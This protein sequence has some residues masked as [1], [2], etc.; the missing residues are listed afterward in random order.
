MSL[1]DNSTMEA[2]STTNGCAP[3]DVSTVKEA[4]VTLT[5]TLSNSSSTSSLPGTPNATRPSKVH[6]KDVVSAQ[7][8][9]Q[10]EIQVTPCV[11]ASVELRLLTGMDIYFKQDFRLPTGS[12]KERGGR[13]A[14]KMLSAEQKKLGVIAA[15]AGN[16]ALAL[17]YHGLQLGIPVT[18]VMPLTAPI[19]KV[20]KC[21]AFGAN[22]KLHG[23][24]IAEAKTL[25]MQMASEQGLQYIN[26][27]D[28]EA[29]IAGQGTMALE[30]LQQVKDCDAIIVP[31]GGAGLLA[32]IALVMK[33]MRPEVQVIAVE[34]KNC[35]S[36]AAAM[37][38][39]HVVE[40]PSVSSLADGLAVPTVGPRSF[41]VA[42][43]RVDRVLTV[44]E[45]YIAMAVLNL[46]E[47]EKCVVEGAG[48]CGLAACLEGLL[49]D[50]KGK[51]VVMPLCGGNIDTTILGRCIDRGLA[52][53]GRLCRFVATVSDRPGGI[54]KLTE[55]LG[56]C[57]V[58]I[59][60]IF[61]ERA[62]LDTDVFS[63]QVKCVVETRDWDHA[64][65]LR[66]ALI[67]AKYSIL[68]QTDHPG[69]KETEV[70]AQ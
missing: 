10:D 17:A 65:Q 38:A 8:R 61:H 40:T 18:V 11:R 9:I 27:Y 6:F 5:P 39:G 43:N 52:A 2:Q 53:S 44:S 55:L 28:D 12:F 1:G 26:G 41:E 50:L 14:L 7:L 31:T 48:A 33:N 42:K 45:K 13:N 32:G 59:K 64:A 46:V 63:V 47:M 29:I 66:Q 24:N 35:P 25:A 37:K 54:R 56:N 34:S 51:K 57:E 16:H 58:S 19:M 69:L 60:D 49:D 70:K 4:S 68:W 62:W 30:I 21:R 67:D 23:A 3:V 22:V 20:S 36:F 15:S